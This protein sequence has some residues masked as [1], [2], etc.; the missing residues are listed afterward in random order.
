MF[1]TWDPDNTGTGVR[2]TLNSEGALTISGMNVGTTPNDGT[3][4]GWG[5]DNTAPSWYAVKDRVRSVSID[6]AS[7]IRVAQ[8]AA[9]CTTC[10][11]ASALCKRLT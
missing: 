11:T 7:R 6:S 5:T 8:S 4:Y 10:S 3:L 9:P 2:W 1:G